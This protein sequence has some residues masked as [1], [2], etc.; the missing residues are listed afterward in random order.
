[1]TVSTADPNAALAAKYP[2]LP[3]KFPLSLDSD[4]FERSALV[5]LAEALPEHLVEYNGGNVPRSVRPEDVPAPPLSVR[6]TIEQIGEAQSWMMLR[7]VEHHAAYAELIDETL[8][9]LKSTLQSV[10]GR[11]V[12][13][14]G[15]VIVSSPS[16]TTPLHFDEDHNILI[17]VE[18]RKTVTVYSQEDR[19]VTSQVEL[20]RFHAGGHRNISWKRDMDEK[21][22]AFD[23]APGDALYIP[24]MAPHYVQ[25]SDEGPA[26]S[27]SMTWRSVKSQKI[28]YLHQLN[29]SLRKKGRKPK[30]PGAS[31]LGDQAKIIKA[32]IERRLG[33]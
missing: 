32:G 4:L 28:R 6:K 5:E 21:G 33:L 29:H 24:P 30:F 12:R 15:F 13:R 22:M 18:G 17:Q 9:R 14:E 7:N 19:S 1:M 10:T 25:V 16:A 3:V 8:D 27:F 11:M 26:F 31:P 20:E 2:N 23:L